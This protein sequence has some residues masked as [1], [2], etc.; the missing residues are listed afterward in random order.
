MP[1]LTETEVSV[2]IAIFT[3]DRPR[4]AHELAE[5]IG[6]KTKRNIHKVLDGRPELFTFLER[7]TELG[8]SRR[9]YSL[10]RRGR[11]Y[12]EMI[13]GVSGGLEGAAE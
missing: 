2:L 5:C 4:R 10:T 13:T 8:H 11:I 7:V 6:M 1:T 12:A 3:S 9:G